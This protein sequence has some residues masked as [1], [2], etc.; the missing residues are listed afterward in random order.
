MRDYTK[1]RAFREADALVVVVYQAT[2]RMPDD[3]RFGLRAQIRRAAV[4]VPA[5]LVEGSARPSTADYR[6]FLVNALGSACEC[7]YLIEVGTRLHQ[8]PDTP[9]TELID[10]YRGLATGLQEALRRLG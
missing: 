7:G 5:N 3:E 4:S 10:R 2:A 1:F 9:A 6:R 8:L